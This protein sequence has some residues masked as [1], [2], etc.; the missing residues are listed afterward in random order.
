[1]NWITYRKQKEVEVFEETKNIRK[2]DAS[3]VPYIN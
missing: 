1:M 3:K 2:N